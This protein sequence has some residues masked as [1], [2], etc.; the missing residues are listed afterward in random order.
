MKVCFAE[1]TGAEI[2]GEEALNELLAKNAFVLLC[3]SA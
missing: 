2:P 1:I 3:V